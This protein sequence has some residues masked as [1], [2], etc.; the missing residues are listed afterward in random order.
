M[1]KMEDIA[2]NDPKYTSHIGS[3]FQKPRIVALNK[4]EWVGRIWFVILI[5]K[6]NKPLKRAEMQ[7]R[8]L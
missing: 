6:K 7:R 2:N 8:R 1:I 4:E 3:E 5:E